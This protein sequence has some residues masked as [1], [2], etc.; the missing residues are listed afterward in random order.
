M[1]IFL[2]VHTKEKEVCLQAFKN[3]LLWLSGSTGSGKCRSTCFCRWQAITYRSCAGL[4]FLGMEIIRNWT[5]YKN[6]GNDAFEQNITS[7]DLKKKDNFCPWALTK[8]NIWV[9]SFGVWKGSPA[10]YSF[11]T[12]H[13]QMPKAR[14]V[15]EGRQKST[16]LILCIKFFFV[17]ISEC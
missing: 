5:F 12:N 14:E 13:F 4:P 11:H 17:W 2:S 8:Y 7:L 1:G 6:F 16:C 10:S 15:G 3:L 9:L